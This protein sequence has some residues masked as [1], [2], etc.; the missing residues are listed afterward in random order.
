[1]VYS[2]CTLNKTENDDVVNQFLSE[3]RD[4]SPCVVPLN[5]PDLKDEYK[6][7]F[8]LNSG[9]DGFF[10]ATFKK[11]AQKKERII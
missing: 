6:H 10:I 3:N 11:D 8:S 7:T 9:G 2:T 5:I 4:F 1:M